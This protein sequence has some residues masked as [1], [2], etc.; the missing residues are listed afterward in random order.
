MIYCCFEH[1]V[2]LLFTLN[3][4]LLID[5]RFLSLIIIIVP[6]SLLFEKYALSTLIH[7]FY[8]RKQLISLYI[9]M[10]IHD[11]TFFAL[12]ITT[13]MTCSMLTVECRLI[14]NYHSLAAGTY[15]FK[16]KPENV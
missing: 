5:L 4:P 3:L 2:H 1:Q 14:Q 7:F 13:T 15:P 10:F 6:R 16:G 9:Q 8:Y 11:R 12:F